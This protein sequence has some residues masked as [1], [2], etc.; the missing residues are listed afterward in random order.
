[1]KVIDPG[2]KYELRTLDG[3]EPTRLK[4]VMRN[5]PPD[6]YPGNKDSYPGT[7]TQEVIRALIDRTKYVQNQQQFAENEAVLYH[8]RLALYQLEV[9]A[10]RTHGRFL[11]VR[12]E[13]IENY[14]TCSIC[15]HV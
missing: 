4:F 1:M 11:N 14:V 7:T 10:A 13:C 12:L 2:H 3:E 8:L 5:N 9:R 6:K 15:G